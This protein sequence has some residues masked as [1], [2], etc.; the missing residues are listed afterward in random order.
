[1]VKQANADVERIALLRLGRIADLEAENVRLR[2]EN[3]SLHQGGECAVCAKRRKRD[4]AKKRRQ[5]GKPKA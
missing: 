2:A 4:A 3:A 1:V 5:R